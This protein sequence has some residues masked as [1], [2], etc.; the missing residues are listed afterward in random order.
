ML[1]NYLGFGWGC[2]EEVWSESVPSSLQLVSTPDPDPNQP[3]RGSLPVSHVI[4]EVI[5][6]G[7][8]VGD[9]GPRLPDFN[10]KRSRV[11]Y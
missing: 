2:G 6:S 11:T 3:Q 9:L 1:W 5:R 8:G 7:V 10:M 4:L